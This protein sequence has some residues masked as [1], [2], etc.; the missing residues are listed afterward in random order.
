MSEV[1]SRAQG[2]FLGLALGDALGATT[3]FMTPGEIR[4]RF[5]VHRKIIGGGWLHLKAGR[6]TDDTEMSLCIARALVAAGDWDLN[7][8]ADNFVAW[9]RSKPIDIGATCRRGIRDYMLKGQMECRRNE[10]DAG[11]GAVMRMLPVALFTLGDEQLLARC[12]LEQA[13][14]THNHPLSDAAC[15]TVGRM[16]QQALA[17]ADRQT[18]HA[19]SRELVAAHPNFRFNDYRGH[20][21]GYVVETLQTV[22]HYLFTTA[23]FEECLVGVV[24]QGG[25]ADTTGAIAGMIAG[26]FYGPEALPGSWLRRLDAGVRSEI[27]ALAP[28]LVG[29]SPRA[30][31]RSP[32]P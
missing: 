14:L 25:D 24:N 13:R 31:G 7:A 23:T 3:E 11:N 19:L 2:A 20:A 10:W 29:L 5:G 30:H 8:I 17:G 26:A 15:I 27:L 32:S 21:G 18:L 16:V 6:V 1:L 12:A 22:F 4:S 9:M 28:Q